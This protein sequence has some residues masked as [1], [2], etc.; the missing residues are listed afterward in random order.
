MSVLVLPLSRVLL[1]LIF[2]YSGYGKVFG[3][4]AGWK[5]GVSALLQKSP[6][7]QLAQYSDILAQVAAYGEFVG[8]I[9]LFL[10]VLSRVSAFGLTVFVLLA[11][12]LAHN[13]WALA[14]AKAY[15]EQLSNFLKNMG[16]IGGLLLI[17]VAGGGAVSID[18]MFRRPQ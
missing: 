9:L 18:G 6:A 15:A 4:M 10:G 14:D 5:T 12:V 16:L 13:F 8:G 17:M 3:G 1:S 2:I 7:P 11:S